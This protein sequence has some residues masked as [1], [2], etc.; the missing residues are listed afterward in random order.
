MCISTPF[1]T[2][3]VAGNPK[4][5][6]LAW[7]LVAS[8]LNLADLCHAPRTKWPNFEYAA[9]IDFTLG[10]FKRLNCCCFHWTGVIVPSR[11]EWL[12]GATRLWRPDKLL[13]S[14]RVGLRIE[15]S[16]RYCKKSES[17]K[18]QSRRLIDKD[19][20]SAAEHRPNFSGRLVNISTPFCHTSWCSA[21]A[22]LAIYRMNVIGSTATMCDWR[23][24]SGAHGGSRR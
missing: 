10:L 22:S 4:S 12:S 11:R 21:A 23:F 13:S 1:Y 16:E 6:L 18:C 19:A 9:I 15:I 24:N 3:V 14:P 8:L 17:P 7:V 5:H 2:Q 20:L